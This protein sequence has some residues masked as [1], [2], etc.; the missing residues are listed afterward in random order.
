MPALRFHRLFLTL[1]LLA[2]LLLAVLPTVGRLAQSGKDSARTLVE[3]CTD[4]GLRLVDLAAD[5]RAADD[6]RAPGLGGHG[7][8]DCAYCSLHWQPLPLRPAVVVPI[9]F[10]PPPTDTG[11]DATPTPVRPTGLGSRGPPLA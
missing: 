3:L 1:A 4:G 8:G 11:L 6:A 5:R 7:D 2:A 10:A 9:A